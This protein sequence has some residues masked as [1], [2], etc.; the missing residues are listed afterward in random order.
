LLAFR[1]RGR[2]AAPAGGHSGLSEGGAFIG[3]FGGLLCSSGTLVSGGFKLLHDQVEIRESFVG[4][5][6]GL[7]RVYIV[8]VLSKDRLP[9]PAGDMVQM[10]VTCLG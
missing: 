4:E 9:L 3:I 7:P 5:G 8:L 1:Q 10:N 6:F 2:R